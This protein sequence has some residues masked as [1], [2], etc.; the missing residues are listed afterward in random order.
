MP[1]I[2]SEQ[3]DEDVG[4]AFRRYRDYLAKHRRLFPRSA[5]ALATSDWYFDF[6]DRRC[7]HDAWLE[8]VLIS[9]PSA[10]GR[11]Q[12]RKVAITITLLGAY[13]DKRLIFT[14]PTVHSYRLMHDDVGLGHRDWRYD[15]FRVSETGHLVHE[16]QWRG[17][18]EAG[19]WVIVADDVRFDV[20]EI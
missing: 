18:S 15:E 12:Y 7:P 8:H 5:Y 3:R 20:V 11:H 14:Y 19:S 10:G 4:N 1:F 17:L 6:D 9:E 2:L 13:H 16:I